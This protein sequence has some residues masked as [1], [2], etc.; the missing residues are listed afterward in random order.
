MMGGD[1]GPGSF[2]LWLPTNYRTTMGKQ[3]ISEEN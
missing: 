3:H 1:G 2:A